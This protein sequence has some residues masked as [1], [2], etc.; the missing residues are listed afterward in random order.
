MLC[1]PPRSKG[2][3]RSR[4]P[5][6][7]FIHFIEASYLNS[8]R[9]IIWTN[10]LFLSLSD[11]PNKCQDHTGHNQMAIVVHV[12]LSQGLCWEKLG[13]VTGITWRKLSR[14]KENWGRPLFTTNWLHH[15]LYSFCSSIWGYSLKPAFMFVF[16]AFCYEYQFCFFTSIENQH[17][18][19]RNWLLF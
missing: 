18:A 10:S 13:Q 19:C 6:N 9:L 8:S 4:C 7:L 11:G 14:S 12:C 17:L 16:S 2:R 1:A 3:I 15:W 5:V